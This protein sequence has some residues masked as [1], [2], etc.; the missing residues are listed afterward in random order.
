LSG[1][2]SRYICPQCNSETVIVTPVAYWSD[3]W[4]AIVHAIRP[5]DCMEIEQVVEQTRWFLSTTRPNRP[6][7]PKQVRIMGGTDQLIY[8]LKNPEEINVCPFSDIAR[9]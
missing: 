5:G 9:P 1:G 4:V 6:N 3:Q 8:M 7:L 2:L